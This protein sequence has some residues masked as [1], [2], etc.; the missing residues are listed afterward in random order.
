MKNVEFVKM[1]AALCLVFILAVFHANSHLSA[2]EEISNDSDL[3]RVNTARNGEEIV[4]NPRLKLIK[5]FKHVRENLESAF[6]F[7]NLNTENKVKQNQEAITNTLYLKPCAK[8]EYKSI[9]EGLTHFDGKIKGKGLVT[10]DEKSNCVRKLNV[11]SVKSKF[12]AKGNPQ[13]PALITFIDGSFAK[14][15]F[16]DG[17]LQGYYIKIWCRFG[18]CDLFDLDAWRAPRFLKEISYFDKGQRIGM[19]LEFKVGGGFVI[20]NVDHE[21]QLTGIYPFHSVEIF[22]ITQILREINNEVQRP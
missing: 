16:Q 15:N 19:A 11:K 2:Q 14:A 4:V 7:K 12:N 3:V 13:G 17:L 6:Q 10:F 18:S 8:D 5:W 21:G 1:F 22:S 20:G 9:S